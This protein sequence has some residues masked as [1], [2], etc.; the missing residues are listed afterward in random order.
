MEVNMSASLEFMAIWLEE[1]HNDKTYIKSKLS[2]VYRY[3]LV[4]RIGLDVMVKTNVP[5]PDSSGTTTIPH[6]ASCFTDGYIRSLF[7]FMVH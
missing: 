7:Q 5:I 4:P 1:A 2:V 3:L 6:T